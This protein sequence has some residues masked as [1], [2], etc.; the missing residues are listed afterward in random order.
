MINS[1]KCLVKIL[2]VFEKILSLSISKITQEYKPLSF[3]KKFITALS[4]ELN[5]DI[6]I[7]NSKTRLPTNDYDIT[8][9]K[10]KSLILLSFQNRFEFIGKLHNKSVIPEF[11]HYD[12]L[13]KRIYTFLYE[14]DRIF[15][16]YPT[17][18]AY[19]PEKYK[20]LEEKFTKRCSHS[21]NRKKIFNGVKKSKKQIVY[22]SSS[23]SSSY[24]NEEFEDD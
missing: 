22:E 3:D 21:P 15:D 6:Y 12:P 20:Q 17:L 23:S 9:L 24:S 14:P 11:Y 18:L 4:N 2:T 16:L 7:I 5:R 10:R 19:L 1:E 8:V 13:I